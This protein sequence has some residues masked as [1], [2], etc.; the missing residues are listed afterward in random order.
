MDGLHLQDAHEE[1]DMDSSFS[2]A[3]KDPSML[4]KSFDLH[5]TNMNTNHNHSLPTS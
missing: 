3:R 2:L 5:T 4:D 1:S